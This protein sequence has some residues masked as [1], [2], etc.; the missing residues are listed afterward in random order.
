MHNK[1]PVVIFV[2][3][4]F[5]SVTAACQHKW[6]YWSDL[7]VSLWMGLLPNV[8]HEISWWKTTG[9]VQILTE[10]RCCF[11]PLWMCLHVT[12]AR[13]WRFVGIVFSKFFHLLLKSGLEFHYG[14]QG[15]Y[16]STQFFAIERGK[17]KLKNTL[18]MLTTAKKARNCCRRLFPKFK[19]WKLD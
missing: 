10:G 5:L 17:F 16:R 12:R 14:T 19:A 11:V 1:V 3:V 18:T 6:K 4:F 9:K 2:C 15:N 7:Q 8:F 13:C